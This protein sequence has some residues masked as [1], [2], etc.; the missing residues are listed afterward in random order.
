VVKRPEV[1]YSEFPLKSGN[2]VTQKL[3]ARRGQDD[4]INIE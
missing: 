2:S 4:I 3:C 1:L